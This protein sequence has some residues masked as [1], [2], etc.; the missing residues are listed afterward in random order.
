MKNCKNKIPKNVQNDQKVIIE[1]E[2]NKKRRR[3]EQDTVV[4]FQLN[5]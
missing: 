2:E 4:Y 5:S 1:M 3:S